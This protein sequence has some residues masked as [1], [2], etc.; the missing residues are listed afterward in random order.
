MDPFSAALQAQRMGQPQQGYS[1]LG[2]LAA[3]P[4]GQPSPGQAPGTAPPAQTPGAAQIPP[5]S[6]DS[7]YLQAL[8]AKYGD[9]WMTGTQGVYGG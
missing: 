9:E 2:Q 1:S 5:N 8:A 7:P 6:T 3:S 4:Q